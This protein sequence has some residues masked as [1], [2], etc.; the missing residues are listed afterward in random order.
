MRNSTTSYE[1]ILLIPDD[2]DIPTSTHIENLEDA[3]SISEFIDPDTG[4]THYIYTYDDI[5]LHSVTTMEDHHLEVIE[6]QLTDEPA[7]ELDST[8]TQQE[9][10]TPATEIWQ[11]LG[12]MEDRFA[13]LHLIDYFVIGL[14]FTVSLV[15]TLII[16]PH[17]LLYFE[18][19]RSPRIAQEAI[20]NL[21]M[22]HGRT[23]VGM[24]V[25]S[26]VAGPCCFDVELFRGANVLPKLSV[27]FKHLFRR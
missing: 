18:T 8:V 15:I 17:L 1:S 20:P 16:R 23:Y 13:V 6:Q 7:E 4:V 19:S 25:D 24:C 14:A 27:C 12:E 5:D 9:V 2:L 21:N 11:L 22:T 10:A 3:D 26:V